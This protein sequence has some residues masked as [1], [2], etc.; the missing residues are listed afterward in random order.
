MKQQFKFYFSET[1]TVFLFALLF[2]V[3]LSFSQVKEAQI[4]KLINTYTAYNTF[5][6]SVL[7]A[8]NGKIMYKKGFGL[9]NM[10][11]DIPNAPNTKHRLGSITKQFTAMLILQLAEAGKIDLQAPITKYLP[12][13]PKANGNKITTHHLLTHTSG[14]PNY[15]SFP[16]FFQNKSRNP[17]TPEAFV[18]EF[19]E[20]ALDFTPGEKFNYSNS[21]Y[22][23]L[24][25]L[26]EKISGKSYEQMLQEKIFTP[27]NM[28]DSGY[29]HHE[30]ILKNRATGY[31][32]KGNKF[33]NSEYLDMSIPYAA[34]SL[35]A[36]VEDLFLWDQALYTN[37]LLSKEYMNLFFKKHTKAGNGYYSYGWFIGNE[38]IG[39]TSETMATIAHGGG[40]N[41]FNTYI[42]RATSDQS[43]IV[44][45]NNTGMAPLND[46]AQAIR[47]IM[48]NKTYDFPKKSVA[49]T[50]YDEIQ[51]KGIESAIQKYHSIKSSSDYTL[52]EREIN[53]IGYQLLQEEKID[54]AVTVFK[55]NVEAFP[56]SYNAYDSYAEG[57]MHQGNKELA[58]ENYKK[59]LVINPNNQ[60]GIDYLKK[61]GEDVSDYIIEDIVVADA[62]LQSYVGA[63]QITPEFI[64]TVT[65]EGSQLK[66]QATGQP[67]FNI[68]PKSDTVFYL[69][70]V[71]AQ[72]TFNKNEAG[73]VVSV[74]LLQGG[75]EIT[76][77]KM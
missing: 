5:N 46:I 15:T 54:E 49:K 24:G 72:L 64:I 7:I 9:A 26:V 75:R 70:V 45:L 67:V 25:V 23:L 29:D 36:T 50:I 11:W 19:S 32:P 62:V 39:N 1:N 66:T 44:L 3:N 27:L 65:K 14:I 31:E 21:G 40:I 73:D 77:I 16:D 53:T 56:G 58:I 59:S 47:G 34:G 69:K 57:L 43:L 76:G 10:E 8:E 33:V 63:Y 42:T 18:K 61:L 12:D 51:S 38:P 6:G 13:Y 28:K 35:Y 52:E 55:W 22:F 68:F 4:T 74:T 30:T 48:Y 41:G 60:N 71:E 37:K 2:F 17:Y 20:M